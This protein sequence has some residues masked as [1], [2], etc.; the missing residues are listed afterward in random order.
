M[1]QLSISDV[2]R[3]LWLEMPGKP[4]E[5]E[6]STPLLGRM[7]HEVAA[8]L[9][10]DDKRTQW[11][12]ALDQET[13]A[14]ARALEEHIYEKL[15][16][17]RLTARQAALSEEGESVLGLWKAV[18]ELSEWLSALLNDAQ[19]SGRIR[20]DRATR[21]WTGDQQLCLP[22]Q[23]LTWDVFEPGWQAPVR[24]SGIADS[25]WKNPSTGR[26]C[27]VEYKLGRGIRE[28]DIAQVCLYHEML[29]ASGC[30]DEDGAVALI[31]FKPEREETFFQ[32][33]ELNVVKTELRRLIGRLAGVSNG[34][35][36]GP[37]PPLEV[38]DEAAMA[39]KRIVETYAQYGVGV[40]LMGEPLVGPSFIRYGVMPAKGVKVGEIRR[41]QD[42]LQVHMNLETPPM[43]HTDRGRLVIDVKRE[44]PQAVMFADILRQLPKRDPL[45]GS[46]RVPLGVDLAG[47]LHGV[48]LS[49]NTS[50]HLLVAGTAGA[51]KSEWLRTALAG[52][53]LMN[54]PQTLQLVLID[55]K[56]SA[57]NGLE[58]SP[59]M[60][61]SWNVLHPV[62]RPISEVLDVLIEEMNN[63]NLLFKQEGV[64]DLSAYV[65]KVRKP[66][67]RIILF[68]DE[69]FDLIAE[70]K[71]RP[72]IETRIARLGAKGR[73]SGIHLIIAT[74]YPKADVVT[75]TLKANLSG[76]VCLRMTD[77]RQ[78]QVV[79][80]QAGAERLLGKGDLLF[81]DIGEPKRLQA[82]YL[83]EQDRKSIFNTGEY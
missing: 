58:G 75:G 17:P 70:K 57:F 78:S 11:Q 29:A 80:G 10:G 50:P 1:V 12:D 61:Q 23:V 47:H 33:A 28:L 44:K 13:V 24:V 82:A 64:D 69:Y 9:L 83:P 2:R 5:G 42:E 73:S 14:D 34:A 19:R 63:R 81:Q 21:Q 54:A 41:L 27:V 46:A 77:G 20:F 55:P 74:Q 39:G 8:E 15:L 6:T 72:E 65:T 18:R 49:Q 60:Y 35:P 7:F 67:P 26:W 53:I 36:A 30:A 56:R 66:L 43:I 71:T 62:D 25:L 52:L 79:L 3:A 45:H 22:E 38:N 40:I 68:C 76:R 51:G 16:G 59:Y 31:A 37:A 32:S 48:D 4:P